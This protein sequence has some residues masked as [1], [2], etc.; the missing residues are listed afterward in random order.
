M[1][2]TLA[3]NKDKRRGSRC[4]VLLRGVGWAGV[5]TCKVESLLSLGTGVT[6]GCRVMSLVHLLQTIGCSRPTDPLV[7][8][9]HGL[10]AGVTFQLP[11]SLK[12]PPSVRTEPS[13]PH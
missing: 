10:P 5:T 3:G 11:V 2:S 9:R 13:H 7:G 1:R 8:C 4:R 12:T 6:G